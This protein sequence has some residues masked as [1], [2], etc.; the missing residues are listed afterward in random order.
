MTVSDLLHAKKES[1][2]FYFDMKVSTTR[3][4]DQMAKLIRSNGCAGSVIVSSSNIRFAFYL[5]RNYPDIITCLEGFNAGKEWTYYLMPPK[6]R[7]DFY[8]GFVQRTNARHI[9]WLKKHGLLS[10]RIVYGVD[11]TNLEAALKSGF[12]NIILDY[13]SSMQFNMKR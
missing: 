5:K 12:Q 6:L 7:P 8:S 9:S 10:R 2:L 1:Q 3:D 11:S 13:D 4:A